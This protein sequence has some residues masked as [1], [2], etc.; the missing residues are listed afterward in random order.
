MTSPDPVILDMVA[1]LTRPH[2][3]AEAYVVRVGETDFGRRHRTRVPSLIHQLQH[4]APSG[5]GLGRSGAYE[6]RPVAR[7]E[8]LD[9]L[10]RMDLAAAAWIRELGED[11]S[12]STDAC[13]R[14]LGALYPSTE[15]CDRKPRRGC[16][17]R[18]EIGRDVR[19]WYAHARVLTGWDIEPW[20]PL[21]TCPM[22]GV[23]G[24]L[25]VRLEARTAVCVECHES[26]DSSSYQQLGSHVFTETMSR[27][28]PQ[29]PPC[30]PRG[31]GVTDLH[32]MC[33][34]CGSSRCVNAIRATK[35]RLSSGE[36]VAL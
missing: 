5:E 18:H 26:W 32:A 2:A 31:D 21:T 9:A 29:P 11:D 19:A 16:C 14:R 25:R 10:I 33:P 35:R 8:A 27:K 7:V 1:E 12:G 23:L 24:S 13:V 30:A 34:R 36:W 3:H 28:P 20:K 6:S 22:C 15:C 4:A 17:P